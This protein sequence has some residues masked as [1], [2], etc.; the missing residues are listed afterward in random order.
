[1]TIIDPDTILANANVST[2]EHHEVLDSTNRRAMVL[3]GEDVELPLL[4]IADEQTAGRGRGS[5]EWWSPRGCLM[6]SLAIQR[7]ED[8]SELPPYSLAVGLGV[9]SAI[10]SEL[11]GHGVKVKWPNDVYV[12]DRKISGILIEVPPGDPGKLVIGIGANV[13][14]STRDAPDSIRSTVAT[15]TDLTSQPVDMNGVLTSILNNISTQIAAMDSD[16]PTRWMDHCYLMGKTITLARGN[17]SDTG[18]C[19]GIDETGALLLRTETEIVRASSGVI[20]STHGT[21]QTGG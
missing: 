1:M 4:V 7:T 6:F 8:L 13:N 5:N 18:M 10:A 17:R 14:N 21:H 9:R 16:L 2:I 19:R 11:P 12:G 15:I 20:E 3:L